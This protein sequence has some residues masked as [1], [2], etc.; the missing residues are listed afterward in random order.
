MYNVLRC[1]TKKKINCVYT[2]KVD[3]N[4]FLNKTS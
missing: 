1:I 4:I 2:L 3:K